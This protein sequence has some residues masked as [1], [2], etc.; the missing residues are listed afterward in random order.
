MAFDTASVSGHS[1]GTGRQIG[2]IT[3]ATASGGSGGGSS[4]FSFLG[5]G[6]GG[7]LD[8]AM[9]WFNDNPDSVSAIGKGISGFIGGE[10]TRQVSQAKRDSY[11]HAAS[12]KEAT[13]ALIREA[14]QDEVEIS[15]SERN[16]KRRRDMLTINKMAPQ[17]AKNGV[18]LGGGSA[19]DV[20]LASMINSISDQGDMKVNEKRRIFGLEVEEFNVLSQA[21]IYRT[22]ANEINPDAD[23]LIT[24][25]GATTTSIF[26]IMSR[27]NRRVS[28]A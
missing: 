12:I 4:L 26:D 17:M 10:Q 28:S 7:F 25:L 3:A 2:E 21:D 22:A 24:S 18:L 23:A 27:Q 13:A 15:Q 19:R 5:G 11:L 20:M 6:S 16:A 1:G 14:Q 9:G 8:D